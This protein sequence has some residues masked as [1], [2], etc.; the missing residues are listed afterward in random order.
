MFISTRN[1]LSSSPIWLVIPAFFALSTVLQAQTIFPIN[2]SDSISTCSGVFTDNGGI[3]G[4]H[5]VNGSDT[6]TICSNSSAS[7]ASHIRLTFTEF[8]ISG[9]FEVYNGPTADPATLVNTLDEASNNTNP[10]LEASAANASGCLTLV[11]TAAGEAPGWQAL[12]S[13]VRACQPVIATLASSDPAVMPVD[14][15]YIDVCIGETINF[16]G[17]G[18]YPESG[19]IYEQSD[20]NSTFTW[21]FAD[22]T[23]ASGA[24][25]SHAFT[26]A[27]A[28][29]VQL[30]ISDQNGCSNNNQISQ[31]VRVAPRPRFTPQ[32]DFTGIVCA[33]DT[34]SL[35]AS[36]QFNPNPA[37]DIF[38]STNEI[39]FSAGQTLADTTF[40]PDGNGVEYTTS[41]EFNNF[42]TGQL[43]TNVSDIEAICLNMEHSYAGDLDIWLECPSGQEVYLVRFGSGLAGQF[44]GEPIDLDDLQ[45]GVGYDYCWTSA[46]NQTWPEAVASIPVF[47]SQSIPAG[48]YR[49]EDPLSNFIGCPLNGEWIIH[50]RDNLSIDNGWIFSWGITFADYLFPDLESYTVGFT[51]AAWRPSDD[52]LF[53][54][55]DSIVAIPLAAGQASF[56]YE[57]TD[58]FGCVHDTT[59]LLEVLPFSH[60]DCYDCQPMLD[61]TN[62]V[63]NTTPGTITQASLA[64]QTS[65]DTTIVFRANPAVPFGNA[66]YPSLGGAYR[67]TLRVNSIAPA[68]ITDISQLESICVNINTEN[69]GGIRLFV[70]PP[71]GAFFELSTANG[72]TGANYTNTCFTPTATTSITAG[73]PPFTGDFLPEGNLNNLIGTPINGNWMLLVYHVGIGT[74]LGEVLDWSI[75]FKHENPLTYSWSP[76]DDGNLSCT[77]CPAPTV[78]A[79][80]TNATYQVLVT[81][82]YG[83]SETGILSVNTEVTVDLAF[84]VTNID[85]AGAENGSITVSASNGMEPYS[86]AWSTGDTTATINDLSPGTYTVVVTD[87]NG[88]SVEGSATV[89]EPAAL[90]ISLDN[91]TNVACAADM[92]GALSVTISG[93]TAPYEIVWSNGADSSSISNLSGGEYALLVTDANGCELQQSFIIEEPPVLEASLSVVNIACGD[94]GETGSINLSVG[95]GTSPYTFLW[96]NGAET[97]DLSDLAAGDYSVTITDANNC[98]I[99]LSASVVQA[100][101]IVL[102]ALVTNVACAGDSSGAIDLTVEGGTPPFTILWSNGA[103]TEDIDSLVAAFYTVELTD[104]VGCTASLTLEVTQSASLTLEALVTNLSCNGDGSGAID[105]SVSGGT[106]NYTFLWSD[107]S[108]EEDRDSLEA[109]VYSVVVTDENGCSVEE[110]FTVTEPDA[111]D[112]TFIITDAACAGE[113]SGSIDITVTGGTPPASFLWS[114]GA[115]TEDLEGLTAGI[116]TVSVTDINGCTTSGSAEVGEAPALLLGAAVTDVSCNGE[117]S[118]AVALD[119]S[120]GVAPYIYLWSNGSTEANLVGVAAG[121][122]SVVVT[123]ANNCTASLNDIV[124]S[125]PSLL[126]CEVSIT[127]EAINNN[128]GALLASISGGTA[129]Y[130]LVWSNG[131]TTASLSNL[132]PGTYTLTVTDANG[133]VTSCSATLRAYAGVGDFVFFD[134]NRD[135]IQNIGEGGIAG[136]T[137]VIMSTDGSFMQTQQTDGLGRYLFR[138]LPGDYWINFSRPPGLQASP[139]NQGGD[140]ALDS[141][142]D[143][144]SGTTD[145]ITLVAFEEN[146]NIDAGFFD[147]CNP[148]LTGAGTIG[149]SQ[150]V[151]GPGNTPDLLIETSP[152]TGTIDGVVEYMWMR[153]TGDPMDTPINNWTPIPNSNTVNYQPGP[154]S[155][156]TYFA[157]CVRIDNCPFIESNFIEVQVGDDAVADVQGPV[158]VCAGEALTYQAVG[159]AAG[160][161]VQWSFNANNPQILSQ[162]ANSITVAWASFGQSVVNLSVTDNNCTATDQLV[163]NV[164]SNP[165]NCANG[166]GSGGNSSRALGNAGT[167]AAYGEAHLS[168]VYPN[169]ATLGG[170]VVLELLGGYDPAQPIYL[171]AY[172]ATGRRL[173]QQQLQEGSMRIQLDIF[174]QQAPGLYLLRLQQGEHTETHRLILK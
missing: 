142:I 161:S 68:T 44:V 140:D 124:V 9:S 152:I 38:V 18:I 6:L 40:L 67:N 55:T 66:L 58:D 155:E 75:T 69:V 103:T 169:P 127:Q 167:A 41:L 149:F 72:G 63:V 91:Q 171:E 164:S 101:E 24:T 16:T 139:Q 78:T 57:V 173:R 59:L 21:N 3:D 93:G 120:G 37:S 151:C 107:G 1:L 148:G 118:G 53:Y 131:A 163:V 99:E 113:A 77:D 35:T 39:R 34:L 136:V 170:T 114:N 92:N 115:T 165:N 95:G 56:V 132:E 65:L 25:V 10:V 98:T 159:V 90:V 89:T 158:L 129:P 42:V 96:S 4:N 62:Q 32:G 26:Q 121:T 160:A 82:A 20:E 13:C 60:P 105:L 154:V 100:S 47:F 64:S 83:C 135:G 162:T 76:T 109:A 123:D 117:S 137:V 61:N 138:V 86:F 71:N 81:D 147:P 146:L 45:Q 19:F 88:N 157:R 11:Y 111:L 31:R 22:G 49:P 153:K 74:P 94:S 166:F 80:M 130:E 12:I 14:T 84:D 50:V 133:C 108:T 102:T 27:R 5:S 85:C 145:I 36:T 23:I 33:G 122:Y 112:I 125:E 54:S 15:G 128:D 104:S 70:M 48:D 143:P 79:G 106:G 172:D 144:N 2:A 46:A 174:Q 156:T 7:N 110:S 126:S 51:D 43:V 119:V 168:T 150:E 52:L 28:Y 97:E 73:T 29:T 17:A 141:D 134:R 30:T 8:I 87:A 116:Y